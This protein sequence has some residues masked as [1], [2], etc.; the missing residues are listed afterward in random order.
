MFFADVTYDLTARNIDTATRLTAINLGLGGQRT[1]KSYIQIG[2]ALTLGTKFIGRNIYDNNGSKYLGE[3]GMAFKMQ[4]EPTFTAFKFFNDDDK[5]ADAPIDDCNIAMLMEYDRI[6]INYGF[7]NSQSTATF[8]IKRINDQ[9]DYLLVEDANNKDM[10]KV[11]A[12]GVTYAQE[13][14]IMDTQAFPDYVFEQGYQL[15]TLKEVEQHIEEKGH[16]P[17]MPSAAE[18]AEED[19]IGMGEMQYKLLEKI[20]ELTL[21]ILEQEKRIAKLEKANQALQAKPKN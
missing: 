2:D 17:N 7:F 18:V 21:Y 13:I 6:G 4:M 15:L 9:Y 3:P 5:S 19:G 10:F 1:P 12:D 20:E 11:S 8:N 16:L 14:K